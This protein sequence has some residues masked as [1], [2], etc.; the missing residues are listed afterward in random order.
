MSFTGKFRDNHGSKHPVLVHSSADSV[1]KGGS[2]HSCILILY[3]GNTD[4]RPI[5]RHMS[6]LEDS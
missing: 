5:P 4:T 2:L 1:Y 6:A 3:V